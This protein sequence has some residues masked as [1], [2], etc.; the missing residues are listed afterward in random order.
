MRARYAVS[1][2]AGVRQTLDGMGEAL[3]GIPL[4]PET[5]ALVEEY[6]PDSSM[7]SGS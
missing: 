2:V 6:L 5:E 4:E 3:R 7:E 1:G